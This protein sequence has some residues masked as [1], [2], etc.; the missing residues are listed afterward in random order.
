LGHTPI[1][2]GP[3]M[4]ARMASLILYS[5]AARYAAV[6]QDASRITGKTLKRI[7]IVGG[8]SKN[9]VLNRLTAKATGLEVL[10]GSTESSTVG[11]FAIQLAALD[12]NYNPGRGVTAKAVSAWAS[13]LSEPSGNAPGTDETGNII[14]GH[15]VEKIQRPTGKALV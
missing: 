1:S 9:A 2:E 8:G 10:T 6:L 3:A 11:N 14:P 12:G 4:A 7:Y 13:T 5:L 15:A